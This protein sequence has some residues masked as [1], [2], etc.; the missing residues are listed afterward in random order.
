MMGQMPILLKEIIVVAAQR[1][2]A[3]KLEMSIP[4]R[5]LTSFQAPGK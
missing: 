1:K 4:A 2:G 3:F 5:N